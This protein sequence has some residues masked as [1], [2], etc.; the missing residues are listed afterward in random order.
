MRTFEPTLALSR[1]PDGEYTL[2]SVTLMPNACYS[3][4]R[5]EIGVPPTVRLV[6]E[7]LP[8]LLHVRS[9]KGACL[10]VITPVRHRIRNL[11]LGAQHGKTSVLAFV[12]LN[13]A[14]A[15]SASLR[16]DEPGTN[17]NDEPRPVDTGDWYAWINRMPPGPPSFHVVGTV[18]VGHPGID[19]QL[20]RAAPQGINPA[21]LILDLVLTER[22]GTWPQVVTSLSVRYDEQTLGVAY[23]G[24]LIRVPG[25]DDVHLDVEDVF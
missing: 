12:M 8:V 24:V 2:R 13:G 7:V 1:E 16:V 3:A 17:V 20:V 25:G 15:G 10:Q 21:E 6:P 18:V 14:V 22:P 23:T 19:A 11:R 5:A 4:G 9:R